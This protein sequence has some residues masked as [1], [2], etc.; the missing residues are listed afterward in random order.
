MARN[1]S[2]LRSSLDSEAGSA[3]EALSPRDRDAVLEALGDAYDR[4]RSEAD[5]DSARFVAR[6]VAALLALAGGSAGETLSRTRLGR[7]ARVLRAAGER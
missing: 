3:L 1:L 7:I 2:L 6:C 4:G 5:A